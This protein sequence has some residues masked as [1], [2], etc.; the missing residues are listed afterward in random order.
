MRVKC[1]AQEHNTMSPARDRNQTARSRIECTNHEV[2]AP[3]TVVLVDFSRIGDFIL[4]LSFHSH[5][6]PIGVQNVGNV[7]ALTAGLF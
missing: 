2:T 4:K 3:L 7:N 5:Q 6:L 1:L